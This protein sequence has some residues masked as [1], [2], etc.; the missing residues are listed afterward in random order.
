MNR[1]ICWESVGVV[2][3]KIEKEI[4]FTSIF[5][6]FQFTDVSL[7]GKSEK[8]VSIIKLFRKVILILSHK[9]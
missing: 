2:F 7:N 5:Q 1:L 4:I 3:V 8:Y 9:Y 6:Q